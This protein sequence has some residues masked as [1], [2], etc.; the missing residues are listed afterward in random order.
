MSFIDLTEREFN[1]LALQMA[2]W[3]YKWC[4]CQ[5]AKL[6]D[7]EHGMLVFKQTITFALRHGAAFVPLPTCSCK[8]AANTAPI[9][10]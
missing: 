4:P 10:T 9:K 3:A 8:K 6:I 2:H 5:P 1:M 7:L